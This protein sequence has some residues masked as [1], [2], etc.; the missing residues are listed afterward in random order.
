MVRSEARTCRR[1][2][3]TKGGDSREHGGGGS[4]RRR[5]PYTQ[6]EAPPTP[7]EPRRI[8]QPPTKRGRPA[9]L[10][11]PAFLV[12]QAYQTQSTRASQNDSDK[13]RETVKLRWICWSLSPSRDDRVLGH[14]CDVTERDLLLSLLLRGLSCPSFPPPLLLPP[15]SRSL[16]SRLTSRRWDLEERLPRDAVQTR[17]A[18]RYKRGNANVGTLASALRQ[19]VK[20]GVAA[21]RARH[22]TKN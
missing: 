14:L 21:E 16:R 11:P 18:P 1:R 7:P 13:A 15:P 4:S 22:T 8:S 3:L 5:S 17:G 6:P 20:T 12:Q 10:K 9:G 19:G 2:S